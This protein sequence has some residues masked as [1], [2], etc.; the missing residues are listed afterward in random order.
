MKINLR[1]IFVIFYITAVLIL[2][3][4]LRNSERSAVYQLCKI[5]AQQSSLKQQLGSKQLR[6]E[7]LIN[8]IGISERLKKHK[9]KKSNVQ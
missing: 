4:Y 2:T 6:L 1:F 5:N 3:V 7:S 8:P 9:N